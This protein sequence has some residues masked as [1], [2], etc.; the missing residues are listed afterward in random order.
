VL[1]FESAQFSASLADGLDF[2]V[3]GGVIGGSDLVDALGDDVTVFDDDAAEGAAMAG[4][5]ALDGKLDRSGHEGIVCMGLHVK[6]FAK[7]LPKAKYMLGKAEAQNIFGVD[8][9][10][11]PT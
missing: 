11:L 2:G 8:L 4:L 6:Y 10:I 5:H 3:G 7:N 9:S 1:Q